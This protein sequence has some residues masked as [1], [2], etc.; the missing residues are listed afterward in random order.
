MTY[1]AWAADPHGDR[2]LTRG[3][4]NSTNN[5]QIVRLLLGQGW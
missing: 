3:D 2:G 5:P 1:F 4:R